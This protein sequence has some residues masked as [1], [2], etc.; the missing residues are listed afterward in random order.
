MIG[1]FPAI[2]QHIAVVD[3]EPRLVSLP[4]VLITHLIQGC[5][6]HSLNPFL[7]APQP[8]HEAVPPLLWAT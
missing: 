1:H 2:V 7:K 4:Q 6:T 3:P 8:Q 5:S